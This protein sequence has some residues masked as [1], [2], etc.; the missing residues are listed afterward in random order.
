[1]GKRAGR[2]KGSLNRS[3]AEPQELAKKLG[4]NPLEILLLMA[5]GK[6]E[7]LGLESEQVTVYSKDCSNQEYRIPIA[8][9]AKAAADAC[10]YLYAQLRNI[11]GTVK[12][13]NTER[14]LGHLSDEELDNL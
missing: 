2:Q 6:W 12:T 1:M 7:E 14:P 9:R 13:V 10:K 3:K 5:A 8:V 11:E 4:V